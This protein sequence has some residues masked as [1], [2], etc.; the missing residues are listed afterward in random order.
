[1]DL[2][3]AMLQTKEHWRQWAANEI[4]GS[5]TRI[6]AATDAAMN[7]LAKG[8]SAEQAVAAARAS[9]PTD[10]T[11]QPAPTVSMSPTTSEPPGTI[12]GVVL[13]IQ[14]RFE[15]AGEIVWDLRVAQHDDAGN[16]IATVPVE[17]RG[18]TLDGSINIGD[19]LEIEGKWQPGQV[20]HPT[21]ILDVTSGVTYSFVR[22]WWQLFG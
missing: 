8:G 12:R 13:S 7:T 22:P 17:I 15:S 1:M 4:G 16:T 18:R 3:P 5:Q 20:L 14:Q 9:V 19:V 11:V 10:A 2:S 6:D 21:Q